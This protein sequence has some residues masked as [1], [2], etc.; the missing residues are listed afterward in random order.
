MENLSPMTKAASRRPHII[1][2]LPGRVR[3]HLPSWPAGEPRLEASLL[4]IPGVRCARVNQF[5]SNVLFHFDPRLTS[6]SALAEGLETAIG[7]AARTD[8]DS[9]REAGS[10]RG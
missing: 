5:T 10:D 4:Q 3:I 9:T 6:P 7:D 8:S 1:H 2:S